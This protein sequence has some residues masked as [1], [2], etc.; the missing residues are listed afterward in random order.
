MKILVHIE[1]ISEHAYFMQFYVIIP[2]LPLFI[3]LALNV[4]R[5]NGDLPAESNITSFQQNFILVHQVLSIL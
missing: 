2:D 5:N 3:Q 1:R 4:S